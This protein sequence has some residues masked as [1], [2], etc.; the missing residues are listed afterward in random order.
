V[1]ITNTEYI[2]LT[3]LSPLS[4]LDL[5][6]NNRQSYS[7]SSKLQSFEIFLKEL[8]VQVP[9]NFDFRNLNSLVIVNE[10]FA[11]LT[12]KPRL[13]F[14]DTPREGLPKVGHFKQQLAKPSKKVIYECQIPYSQLNLVTLDAVI[15]QIKNGGGIG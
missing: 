6:A 5:L 10:Q 12:S 9:A 2:S 15:L 1:A 13:K 3:Y 11:R 4:T 14:E 7:S 8:Q